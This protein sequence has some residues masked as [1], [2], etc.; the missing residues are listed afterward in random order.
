MSFIANKGKE[1]Y[2]WFSDD[3]TFCYNSW[4]DNPERC[5]NEGCFRHTSHIRDTKIPHSFSLLK[6]T[7]LCN[8]YRSEG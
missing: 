1:E 7:D 2:G 4:G 6:D 8:G 3:I 5:H